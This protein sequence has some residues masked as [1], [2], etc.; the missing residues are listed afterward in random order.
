MAEGVIE[1]TDS[2]FEQLTAS[3]TPTLI[4]FWAPWCGPCRAMTPIIEKLAQEQGDKV[5]VCKFNTD[6]NTQVPGSLGITSIPTILLYK[7]GEMKWR[8]VGAVRYEALTEAIAQH[9]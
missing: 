8:H 6:E 7:G 2:T 4:D 9:S 1:L 3:E 5:Q